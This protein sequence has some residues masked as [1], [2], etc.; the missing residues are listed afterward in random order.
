MYQEC[1]SLRVHGVRKKEKA[2]AQIPT[3]YIQTTCRRKYD[4]VG[5]YN[6][7]RAA[8]LGFFIAREN[9]LS[10]LFFDEGLGITSPLP[11]IINTIEKIE[12]R[13]HIT[14]SFDENDPRP[15]RKKRPYK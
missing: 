6:A 5:P 4:D 11:D 2:T 14:T 1:A 8:G 7:P 12:K 3:V 15:G 10:P 13:Y 9:L